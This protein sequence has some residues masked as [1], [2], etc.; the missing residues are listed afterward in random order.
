MR[1]VTPSTPALAFI[2]VCLAVFFAESVLM[3]FLQPMYDLGNQ[4]ES[5]IDATTLLMVMAPL[6]F[7]LF[8]RPMSRAIKEKTEAETALRMACED[9]ESRVQA[10]TAELEC[11]NLSLLS[12]IEQRAE[13]MARLKIQEKLLSA[14]QQAVLAVDPEGRIIFWNRFAEELLGWTQDEVLGL[15]LTG[16]GLFLAQDLSSPEFMRG[17][18]GEVITTRRDG[19]RFPT[20]LICSTMWGQDCAVAGFVY[21]LV[22]ITERREAER[23]LQ[24]SEE[25]YSTVVENS[26]TGIFIIQDEK[27]VFANQRFCEIIGH[28]METLSEIEPGAVVDPQDWPQVRLIWEKRLAGEET[29]TQYDYKIF[30]YHQG[31]RWIHGCSTLIRYRNQKALVVNIQDVTEQHETEQALRD[32]RETLQRLSACLITA[33][34][35]ERQRVAQ[36][37]H[38]SIG[39]SLSAILFLG[40]RALREAEHQITPEQKEGIHTIM[41][42]IQDA[43]VEVRRISMALRPSTLDDLG[44]LATITWFT[45]EFTNT[46]PGIAVEKILPIEESQIPEEL[47]ITLFRILQEATNN[48]AKYSHAQHITLSLSLKE[49]ILSLTVM[50]DG[51][52]FDPSLNRKPDVSGGYGLHSM[53]ERAELS[54]GSFLIAS[55]PGKGTQITAWWPVRRDLFRGQNHI[56]GHEAILDGIG[57]QGCDRVK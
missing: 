55:T 19:F 23:A 31:V 11:T 36:E 54:G 56:V 9:L 27:I 30:S 42:L 13:A 16:L 10:R 12:E 21:T 2:L 39:S 46:H 5:L 22:D 48:A 44:F 18:V 14:V 28:P 50:D 7:F 47:K 32:S 52:G 25:K 38:D 15:P 57:G 33:Q 41:G 40:E 6:L 3:W 20:D 53:K 35:S 26:P 51:I 43:M 1:G 8:V 37:L 24:H 34:E 29:S 4:L 17:W 45:R 49:E